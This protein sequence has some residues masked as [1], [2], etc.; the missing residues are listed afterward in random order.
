MSQ[1]IFG[2][3]CDIVDVSRFAA[4]LEKSPGLKAR[5]FTS[6][7]IG[8][9]LRS[10]AAR[11]AAKE[12]LIKALGGDHGLRWHDIE[13]PRVADERPSFSAT[14]TLQ[15]RLADL[16]VARLHLSLSHETETAIAYVVAEGG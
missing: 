6:A 12:A 1:G 2:I 11:F 13:V 10:L 5:L 4:Q 7:E 9:P 16:G 14:A 15:Q 3:G 8:L